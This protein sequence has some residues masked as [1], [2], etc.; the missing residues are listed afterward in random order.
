MT[1]HRFL[2]PM[3][4]ARTFAARRAGMTDGRK[5]RRELQRLKR[6]VAPSFGGEDVPAEWSMIE[7]VDELPEADDDTIGRVFVKKNEDGDDSI[8]FG[9][10]GPDGTPILI[11]ATSPSRDGEVLVL[12]WA[13][14]EPGVS[15]GRFT[16]PRGIA[17]DASGNIYVADTTNN[18]VEKFDATGAFVLEFGSFGVGNGQFD[19]PSGLAIDASGNVYVTDTGNNRV[20]KFTSAGAY[21]SQFGSSGDGDGEFNQPYGIAI[22]ASGGIWITDSANSRVQEFTSGGVYA[23]Q[24]GSYG[25]A[26]GQFD[27]PYGIDIDS[28]G[29]LY[30]ADF[31]RSR[32]QVFDESGKYVAQ[33]GKRGLSG[34]QLYGPVFLA[35]GAGDVGYVAERGASRVSTFR[36]IDPDTAPAH[37]HTPTITRRSNSVNV[38]NTSTGTVT[39]TCNA[40]EVCISCGAEFAAGPQRWIGD[41]Y[42][43]TANGCY[44]SARNNGT[45]GAVTLTAHAMCMKV[46][47]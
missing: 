8:A 47:L 26:D 11:D 4:P 15:P 18:R 13:F 42:V 2:D 33:V 36:L 34:G 17:I 37:S 22:D 5:L 23:S 3:A 46:P 28:A 7:E 32:I 44:V 30:V 39:S 25:T 9:V 43:T 45:A 14:G 12:R 19:T 6:R 27:V 35:I 21:S 1:A 40:D 38:G 24:F 10:T 20:Q 16:Q 31:V 41:V 29:R